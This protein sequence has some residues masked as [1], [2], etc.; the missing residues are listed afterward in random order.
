[1]KEIRVKWN[2]IYKEGFNLST[3]S[4]KINTLFF[5]DEQVIRADS[6]DNLQR[7]RIHITK[8]I[9]QILKGNITRKI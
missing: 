5:A 7:W 9:K 2:Q 6:E 1:M 4:T 8:H 3:T